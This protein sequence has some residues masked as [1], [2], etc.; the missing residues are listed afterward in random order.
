[1]G[2]VHGEVTLDGKPL[3]DGRVLF[4][5]VDGQGQT[6]GATITDG[7]F[8]AVVPV[9]KMQVQINANKVIGQKPVYDSPG[10]P[11]MDEVI[12]IIPHRYNINS[13]LTLDVKEGE[14]PVK[15]E[16]KSK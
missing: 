2:T 14:Q 3:K 16:L 8:T 5:P 15:Y 10:S 11:M 7:K 1:M 12:E 13:E 4:T 9:A 6:G